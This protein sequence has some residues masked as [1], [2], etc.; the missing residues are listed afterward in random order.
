MVWMTE[1]VFPPWNFSWVV[2]DRLAAMAWP[3]TV[4]SLDYIIQQGVR[5]LVTLSAEKLPPTHVFPQLR[6]TVIS[7]LEFEAPTLDQIKQFI[8]ICEVE[9]QNNEAVGVHCRMGRGRTGVM[10]ACYL[11]RFAAQTPERAITSLRLTRPG[12]VETYAQERVV[13]AYHDF[14]R[15]S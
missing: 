5:H 8:A 15:A 9:D 1:A 14:L 4:A 10:A 12:S 2:P 3:Q 13:L 6:H 7:V 11:V